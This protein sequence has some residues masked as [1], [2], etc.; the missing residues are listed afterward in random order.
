MGRPEDK[1]LS[2]WRSKIIRFCRNISL[3]CAYLMG[4]IIRIEGWENYEEAI[5]KNI[6]VNSIPFKPLNVFLDRSV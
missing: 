5:K 2:G 3:L 4:F 6:R 1:P